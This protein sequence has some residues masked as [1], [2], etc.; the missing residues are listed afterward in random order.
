MTPLSS[1]ARLCWYLS[2]FRIVFSNLSSS[3]TRLSRFI[4]QGKRQEGEVI[5]EAQKRESNSEVDR[6]RGVAFLFGAISDETARFIPQPPA[7]D[8]FKTNQPGGGRAPRN[9]FR[10]VADSTRPSLANVKSVRL[11]HMI[12]SVVPL[13]VTFRGV[14]GLV[15][16]GGFFG[17]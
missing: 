4:R 14:N 9:H 7:I 1:D 8:R 10:R 17:T 15:D 13:Q 5:Q 12:C 3:S 16:R 2:T 11:H 6:T